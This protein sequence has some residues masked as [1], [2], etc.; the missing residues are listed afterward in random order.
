MTKL[1]KIAI[2]GAGVLILSGGIAIGAIDYK[3]KSDDKKLDVMAQIKVTNKVSSRHVDVDVDICETPVQC[4]QAAT[5]SFL[6]QISSLREGLENNRA[7]RTATRDEAVRLTLEKHAT[8]E[9]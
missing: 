6:R 7:N 8:C 5:D 2:G 1:Q 9:Q 3:Q 4:S